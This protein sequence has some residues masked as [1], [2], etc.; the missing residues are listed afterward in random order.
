[1]TDPDQSHATNS[2]S[3]CRAISPAD[4]IWSSNGITAPRSARAL[5][6]ESRAALFGLSAN[7][8]TEVIEAA[9]TTEVPGAPAWYKGVS[10]YR[11][12]PTPLIDIAKFLQPESP[13]LLFNR[14]I[15][16]RVASSTYL[17]AVDKI[18]NLCNLPSDPETSRRKATDNHQHSGPHITAEHMPHRAI[19]SIC[20]YDNRSLAM[21]DLPELLRCTKLL[22][23]CAIA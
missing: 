13:D 17:L 9:E 2:N 18:L 14:A 15:A 7:S 8:V 23:E 1:V 11:S 5:L 22:R 12:Q 10:I 6:F 3:G 4:V 16:V 21:I 20:R 19:S